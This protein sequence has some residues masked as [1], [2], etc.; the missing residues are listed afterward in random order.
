MTVAPRMELALRRRLPAEL[1]APRCLH[2]VE[3]PDDGTVWGLRDEIG[4]VGGLGRDE[5]HRL[6]E[7]VEG[8]GASPSVGSIISAPSTTRGK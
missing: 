4:R 8:F 7:L 5:V 1:R 6:D 3:A 2:L